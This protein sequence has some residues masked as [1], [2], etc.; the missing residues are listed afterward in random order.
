MY[1]GPYWV[2]SL[3]YGS[4][5]MR[6]TGFPRVDGG[7]RD[8]QVLGC[9]THSRGIMSIVHK[10]DCPVAWGTSIYSIRSGS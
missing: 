9:H 5:D 10:G 3:M 1:D 2:I 6:H 8:P 7:Q 4:H